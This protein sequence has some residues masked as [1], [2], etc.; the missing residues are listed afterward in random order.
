MLINV[1]QTDQCNGNGQC[2]QTGIN[3]YQWLAFDFNFVSLF[4]IFTKFQFN[5][6]CYNGFSGQ[7]CQTVN[8]L[9]QNNPCVHGVCKRKQTSTHWF[10]CFIENKIISIN[11]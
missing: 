4:R 3:N 6:N 5:S 9:C 8:N 11:V 10:L 7:F 2:I 1:C